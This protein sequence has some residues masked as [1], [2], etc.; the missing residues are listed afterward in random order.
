LL[1]HSKPDASSVPDFDGIGIDQI[2]IVV[3]DPHPALGI[4]GLGLLLSP[5]GEN[6][7]LSHWS[8]S[9]RSWKIG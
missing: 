7:N 4:E 3:C 9:F 1:I 8:I 5:G 2:A 6:L